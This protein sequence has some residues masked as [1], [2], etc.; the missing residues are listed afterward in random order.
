[1]TTA[2]SFDKL[3]TQASDELRCKQSRSVLVE[4]AEYRLAVAYPRK[5]ASRAS[6]D[7]ALRCAGCAN[8][9]KS[10]LRPPQPFLF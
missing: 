1:M 6:S 2:M 10:S 7:E 4:E 3:S 9:S 8:S 5:T